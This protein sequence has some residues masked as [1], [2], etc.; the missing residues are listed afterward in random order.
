MKLAKLCSELCD[1]CQSQ[2]VLLF[3]TGYIL[4]TVSMFQVFKNCVH[5]V[6]LRINSFQEVLC[7]DGW[8]ITKLNG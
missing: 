8:K 1:L 3:Q 4:W 7:S 6:K 5:I 2:V